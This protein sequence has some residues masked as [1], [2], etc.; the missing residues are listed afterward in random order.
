MLKN[1]KKTDMVFN[2]FV[3]K[4]LRNSCRSKKRF[5][6]CTPNRKI[7]RREKAESSLKVWKAVTLK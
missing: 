4:I 7:G 2:N 1:Y 6:L 5:Y 3:K